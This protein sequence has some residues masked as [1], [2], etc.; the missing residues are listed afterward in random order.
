MIGQYML[1]GIGIQYV[2]FG[3]YSMFTNNVWL[4]ASYVFYALANVT[5][6]QLVNK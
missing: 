5:L 3:V 6:A 2:I 1:Y 4:G